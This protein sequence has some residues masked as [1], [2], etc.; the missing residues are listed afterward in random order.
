[1]IW[2]GIVWKGFLW[3]NTTPEMQQRGPIPPSQ[4]AQQDVPLPQECRYGGYGTGTAEAQWVRGRYS[5]YGTGTVSMA[6]A[7]WV[8]HRDGEY[9]T[10]T[11]G[12]VQVW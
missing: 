8:Q 5:G 2:F 6:Q 11:A 7:R 1:M 10:S 12:T 3:H 9:D 4:R